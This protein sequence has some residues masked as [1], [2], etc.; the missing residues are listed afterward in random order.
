MLVGAGAR[1][2]DSIDRWRLPDDDHILLGHDHK[3][4]VSNC[5]LDALVMDRG[6]IEDHPCLQ[7]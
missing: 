3:F 7:N 1:D 6:I 4:R 5:C 2:D